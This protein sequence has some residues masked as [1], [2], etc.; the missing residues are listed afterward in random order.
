MGAHKP[1]LPKP[2]PTS[3]TL[4]TRPLLVFA[5][6]LLGIGLFRTIRF[7][8]AQNTPKLHP[9]EEEKLLKRL[10]EID[11]SEQYALVA[12]KAGWYPCLHSGRT[13]FYLKAGEIWK[14]GVTSKGQF[15]RY[16]AAFLLR[17]QVSYDIQF[18]GTF[19]EC[20]KHGNNGAT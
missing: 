17:N 19:S 12:K 8:E 20:L 10:Q 3:S 1:E 4:Y 9:K 15:G 16:T 6:L 2:G 14:Y 7:E 18:K 5:V 11:D 13:I